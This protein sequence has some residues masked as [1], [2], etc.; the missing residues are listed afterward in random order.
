MGVKGHW[1]RPRFVSYQVYSDRYELAFGKKTE[2]PP[3]SEPP[4]TL[5]SGEARGSAK[6]DE[7]EDG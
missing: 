7:G 4:E 3:E 2:A 6:E 5:P 1:I